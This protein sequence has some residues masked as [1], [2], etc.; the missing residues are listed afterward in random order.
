MEDTKD[1]IE[2]RIPDLV[3]TAD[4]PVPLAA[5]I[6]FQAGRV[7]SWIIQSR[8]VSAPI[9]ARS[10][11]FIGRSSEA[12]AAL[13]G[14]DV[15]SAEPLD[16]ARAAWAASRVGG[17]TT[18]ALLARL[19]A[20][21]DDFI[22]GE[23]P[24]GP[25]ALFTGMLRAASGDI[26]GAVEDMRMAVRI[27]DVR[28]PIWGALGRLELGRVLSTAEA[29]PLTEFGAA[30]PTLTAARTFFAAGGYRSLLQRVGEANEPVVATLQLGRPCIVG[31]GVHPAVPVK[32]SKGLTALHH[33]VTNRDRIVSAAELAIVI[34]GGA[35]GEIAGLM[36][37]AW[38]QM[39]A[40]ARQGGLDRATDGV[41]AEIRRVFFDDGTRSRV[42]KLLWRT[43]DKLDESC[44]PSSWHL[45]AA[46]RTGH[47]CRY[48]P[49]GE[50]VN[51]QLFSS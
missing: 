16:L 40:R 5:E 37:Q 30:H 38:Q 9:S 14:V 49:A 33:L 51:W 28:A 29:V 36:P 25:I 50:P 10:L 42:S 6:D 7:D 43:I 31:F 44:P 46:V 41:N 22:G 12:Q 4:L 32:A 8:R 1:L 18:A 39:A 2:H 27:G 20:L 34:E 15:D 3:S 17:P 35:A 24:A 11:A 48:E 21:T 45:R 13:D 19:E 23:A 47:A 26:A